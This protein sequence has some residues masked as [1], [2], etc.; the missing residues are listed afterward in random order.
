MRSSCVKQSSIWKTG[1]QTQTQK[2]TVFAIEPTQT[3]SDCLR[4]CYVYIYG[5]R[6]RTC[7]KIESKKN[8]LK[9]LKR[10]Y[11]TRASLSLRISFISNLRYYFPAFHGFCASCVEWR[12]QVKFQSPIALIKGTAFPQTSKRAV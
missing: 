8:W 9:L 2:V 4:R 5:K 1:S 7:L 3:V 11:Y 12:L 6:S 10:K